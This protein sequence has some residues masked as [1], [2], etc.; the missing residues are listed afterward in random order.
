MTISI[1]KAFTAKNRLDSLHAY[2]RLER[3][4]LNLYDID[5]FVKKDEQLQKLLQELKQ[6]HKNMRDGVELQL[7]ILAY[8]GIAPEEKE[9]YANKMYYEL[10]HQRLDYQEK[11]DEFFAKFQ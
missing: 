8:P 5:P 7:E 9:Q 10:K 3:E 4:T 6:L 1:T 2:L 11:R